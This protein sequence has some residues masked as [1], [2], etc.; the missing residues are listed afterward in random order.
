M[1]VILFSKPLESVRQL[2]APCPLVSELRNEHRER[3]GKAGD[4]QWAGIHRV[5]ADVADQ[6]GGQILAAPIVATVH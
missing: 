2:R 3:L 6:A 1:N 5:E 4:A